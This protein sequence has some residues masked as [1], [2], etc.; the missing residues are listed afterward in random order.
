M[1][2]YVAWFGRIMMSS[3]SD[4]SWLACCS[5]L[6]WQRFFCITV[7]YT[8]TGFFFSFHNVCNLFVAAVLRLGAWTICLLFTSIFH[9]LWFCLFLFF[10][11]DWLKDWR[12][13]DSNSWLDWV[14]RVNTSLRFFF[15]PYVWGCVLLSDH[16]HSARHFIPA[17]W[18]LWRDRK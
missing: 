7:S 3:V 1:R 4:V 8:L 9:T 2:T 11:I 14:E 15:I 5:C 18:S 13:L 10:R 16:L 12:V 6:P 17:G